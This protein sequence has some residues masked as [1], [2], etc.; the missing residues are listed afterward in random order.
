M[1]TPNDLVKTVPQLTG[2]RNMLPEMQQP[3]GA[4]RVVG[5]MDSLDDG[6]TL[7]R[8]GGY[9]K[10]VN[11]A[12]STDLY[13]PAHEDGLY[14]LAAGTITSYDNELAP[15]A[16]KTGLTDARLAWAE[17]AGHVL[18]AG[19]VD[20]GIFAQRVNWLPLRVPVPSSITVN[21]S[22][23]GTLPAGS[24]L[25]AACYVHTVSGIAGGVRVQSL[26]L[27]EPKS[28][29]L[30]VAGL[31]GY[32][33][34]FYVSLPNGNEP[35]WVAQH[36][37]AH[38]LAALPDPPQSVPPDPDQFE[39]MP[40]PED[41]TGLAVFNGTV[42]AATYDNEQDVSVIWHSAPFYLQ[43]FPMAQAFD[44]IPAKILGMIA[45]RDGILAGTGEAIWLYREGVW[46][47]L[48][49]FG[50]VSG[51]PLA[52]DR[53][54]N[55]VLW[56]TRGAV[57]WDNKLTALQVEKVAVAPGDT[58]ATVIAERN[59]MKQFLAV[60]DGEGQPWNAMP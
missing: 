26:T 25:V 43:C 34:D 37:T 35:Y 49:D 40:L 16:T 56:T 21:A 32:S 18:Y 41:I 13:S 55:T 17:M 53:D 36:A 12:S 30:S 19:E 48:T 22:G 39:A 29:A 28:I 14:L 11:K 42:F 23:A 20:A 59:G 15:L 51:R 7:A 4:M 24:Y 6:R 31:S 38:T 60:T 3:F 27:T 47:R 46:T 54:W 9:V 45:L 8:R 50:L 1:K 52:Q 58:C 5:N 33:V 2:W 44:Q 57:L 10:V